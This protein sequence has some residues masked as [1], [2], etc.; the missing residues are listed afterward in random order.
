MAFA[1]F[2]LPFAF[3]PIL[4]VAN[5]GGYMGQQKNTPA[6]NLVGVLMLLLCAVTVAT[7]PLLILSGGG[8]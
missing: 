3:L 6:A 7:I 4:V 8:T 5:D 2:S 1:A